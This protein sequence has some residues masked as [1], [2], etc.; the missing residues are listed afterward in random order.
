M[1][2]L[3]RSVAES[4]ISPLPNPV[5]P[6]SDSFLKRL[7]ATRQRLRS[8]KRWCPDDVKSSPGNDRPKV[9]VMLITYNHGRYVAQAL[10]SI[11]MQKRDFKIEI[12]VIDDASTDQTQDIALEYAK[13]HPDIINCYFNPQ[14]VGHIHTQLNTIR[15][16]QTLRGN[17]FA[18]LEGD[19]YWTDENKLAEQ[20]QFLDNNKCFVACAH[21]VQKVYDDGRP[22]EHFLPFKAFGRDTATMVDLV[23]MAGVYHLSSIVYRNVFGLTP[24]PA[25]AD[26]YSCEVTINFTYG[27]FGDFYCIDRYM[28]AYRVHGQGAFSSR[29][30]EDLWLFH[31]HGY[32][33]FAFYLGWRYWNTFAVAVLVF[34]HY[35]LLAPSRG[36]VSHLSWKTKA[37]FW[38]HLIA[39]AP[40]CAYKGLRSRSAGA[41]RRF[42]V[43]I[44]SRQIAPDFGY[45][46]QKTK[47]TL[48][49]RWPGLVV[50]YH[51]RRTFRD[52]IGHFWRQTKNAL[53]ERWPVLLVLYHRI[54]GLK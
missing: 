10:D 27:M 9:S 25:L 36:F 8:L 16:F 13:R 30:L 4:M 23:R 22:P 42:K 29:S 39:A 46:W 49:E 31:L 54:K 32:R 34:S 51:R 5:S 12:N 21:W 26:R 2:S 3:A 11:L 24:P 20:V 48:A 14:N 1:R 28:S 41:V 33:H 45:F 37:L 43:F 35:V 44:S 6:I 47:N 53:A 40:F 52:E 18:L 15:G 19:D 38:A 50:V 7:R 17:Y